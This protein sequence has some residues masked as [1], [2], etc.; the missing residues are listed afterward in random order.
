MKQ[1][2]NEQIGRIKA[3]MNIN[4]DDSQMAMLQQAT[5]EFNEKAEEDLTPDELQEVACT[6]PDSIELPTDTTNEHK[7]KFEEFKVKVKEMVKA[8]DIDGLKQAKRQL[9]E[10]KNQ[11]KQQQNEQAFTG[12]LYT[13]IGIQMPLGFVIFLYGFLF[14][15]ILNGLL[16]LFGI[17]FFKTITDWCTGRRTVGFG[18]R[19]GRD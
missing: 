14:L 13:V 6:S 15:L 11:S 5:Q 2:L 16:S 10:L 4:E 19:F 8:R 17:H 18:V 3:M 9:K 7:Q 1:T 12:T